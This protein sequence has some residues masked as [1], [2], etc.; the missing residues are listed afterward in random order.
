MLLAGSSV[1]AWQNYQ[2]LVDWW[3]LRSYDPPARIVE[4]AKNTT[5][6]VEAEKLF[7]VHYPELNDRNVFR[8]NCTIAEASIV[9]GCYVSSQKIYIFDVDD[10]RLD[11]VHEVTAAHE[12]LHAA[13]DRLS[14]DERTKIDRLTSSV[15]ASIKDSRIIETVEAYRSRDPGIVPDELHSILATEVKDLPDELEEYYKRYFNDR[16]SLVSLAKQYENAFRERRDKVDQYD[17][18]LSNLR[19]DIDS[20]QAGLSNQLAALEQ[21]RR[22]LDAYLAS[23]DYEAYN[24]GVPVFNKQVA[25]YNATVATVR[26]MIERYNRLV[27]ERNAIALEENELIQ[28]IDTR[29]EAIKAE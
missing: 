15:F 1:L 17:K 18:Q 26:N 27:N 29:P 28:A 9:L 10:E 22:R 2:A 23:Q 5:M 24:A 3:R 19:S 7:Y 6:T 16:A 21:D 25:D 14:Q 11:G 4:L 12:M 13:Y 8:Q 20:L